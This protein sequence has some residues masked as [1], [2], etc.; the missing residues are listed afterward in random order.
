MAVKKSPKSLKPLLTYV[1]TKNRKEALNL[2]RYLVNHKLAAC[3]NIFPKITSIYRWQGKVESADEA[4][5]I[6]K[7]D[8][9]RRLDILKA[10]K[11]RHSYSVPCILFFEISGGNPDYLTWL[12]ESVVK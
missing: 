1:V 12:N 7:S 3:V 10:V 9:K 6:V 8:Q 2:G 11:K 5:L 4:V